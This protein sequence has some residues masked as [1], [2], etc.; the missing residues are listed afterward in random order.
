MVR[1]RVLAI[2][3]CLLLVPLS[4]HGGPAESHVVGGDPVTAGQFPFVVLVVSETPGGIYF[5]TG[6]LIRPDWVLTAAHCGDHGAP[7]YVAVGDA[8]PGAFP[9]V[10]IDVL[11]V[12]QWV[13]HPQYNAETFANDVALVRVSGDATHHPVRFNG[14]TVYVPSTIELATAPVSTASSIGDVVIA[15][16][17]RTDVIGET[18]PAA[19]VYW[20]GPIPTFGASQC[21]SLYPLTISASQQLCFATYPN[22][23]QGDSGGAVFRQAGGRFTQF[24]IV[25]FNKGPDLCTAGIPAVAT[26]VPGYVTW[27]NE[28]IDGVTPP[29]SQIQLGWELP[30]SHTDGVASGIS[31][32][33]GWTY[34]RAGT[35]TSVHLERN[36]QHF[37]TLPCCAERGDVKN[38]IP[39]APLLSGFSA[40]VGWA[41]LGDG[42]SE[43]TI[44]VRDSAGNEKRETRTIRTVQ[45]LGG[46][47]FARDLAF[48]GSTFC[49]LGNA[50]GRAL[51]NCGGLNFAQGTCNG[52]ITFGWQNGKQTFEVVEGCH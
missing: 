27:I 25:S 40:A 22:I 15:G 23:C 51:I 42:L 11:A 48:T 36:G 43:L 20:A 29:D 39:E 13:R 4:A 34:S 47:P 21:A 41:N 17:G 49:Q 24:G 14:V 12:A 44:V 2:V 9:G 30:Q 5:C 31:N 46:V 32:A 7:T 19:T 18:V 50:S 8:L 35:I 6:S 45:I 3:L 26:Y 1:T 37:V 38:A 28:Q 16:F 10:E 52:D 33:Q